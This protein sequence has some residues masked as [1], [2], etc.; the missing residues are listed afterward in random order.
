M[1]MFVLLSVIGTLSYKLWTLLVTKINLGERLFYRT[2]PIWK[3]R[4]QIEIIISFQNLANVEESK[5]ISM[6]ILMC[7]LLNMMTVLLTGCLYV[8]I[9]YKYPE[10]NNAAAPN[11]THGPA[12]SH[13]VKPI[14]YKN[15]EFKPLYYGAIGPT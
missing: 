8:Q 9:L 11:S 4:K 10:H 15:K 1:D 5:Q 6:Q 12:V 13:A 3:T 7:K 2:E 14:S